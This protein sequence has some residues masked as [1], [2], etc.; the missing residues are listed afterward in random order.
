MFVW[1]ALV[2]YLSTHLQI[3]LTLPSND[4]LGDSSEEDEGEEDEEED[5]EEEDGFDE[6]EVM[7]GYLTSASFSNCNR[8]HQLI[9]IIRIGSRLDG[10]GRR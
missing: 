8:F 6:D 4:S 3:G 7:V 10:Y 5:G 9:P 1:L 2:P